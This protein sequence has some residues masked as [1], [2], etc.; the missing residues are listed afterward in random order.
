MKTGWAKRI[1][2]ITLKK[3][4]SSGNAKQPLIRFM[5]LAKCQSPRSTNFRYMKNFE[6][7]IF[8]FCHN[9]EYLV[10]CGRYLHV[11]HKSEISLILL[12]H[13]D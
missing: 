2:W 8:I 11:M 13:Y 1:A 6:I 4:G 12:L 7:P 10:G 9:W 3:S 5:K